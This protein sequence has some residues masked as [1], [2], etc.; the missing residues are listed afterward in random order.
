V[1]V[2]SASGIPEAS[3][4]GISA[5]NAGIRISLFSACF[6]E[7]ELSHLPYYHISMG[8]GSGRLSMETIKLRAC[9]IGVL[10]IP[11]GSWKEQDE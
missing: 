7:T 2:S 8:L 11:G 4:E 5:E 6:M 9:R 3:W 1:L 10:G